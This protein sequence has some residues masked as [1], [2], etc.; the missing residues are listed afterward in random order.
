M[1]RYKKID[2]L[3]FEL[4]YIILKII[5]IRKFLIEFSNQ[6]WHDLTPIFSTFTVFFLDKIS[7]VGSILEQIVRG[8]A[9]SVYANQS[10]LHSCKY[11][12]LEEDHSG[13]SSLVNLRKIWTL[14]NLQVRN[15]KFSIAWIALEF[16]FTACPV[17]F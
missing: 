14:N 4:I 2:H 10:D 17:L 8:I 9:G 6:V 1:F 3:L 16:F 15:P 7:R 5:N 12:L 11:L 13:E